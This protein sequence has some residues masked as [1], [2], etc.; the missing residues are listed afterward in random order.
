M[1]SSLSS[2]NWIELASESLA[3]LRERGGGT[4]RE[5]EGEREKM[6]GREGQ[7]ES[8]TC[9]CC[10]HYQVPFLFLVLLLPTLPCYIP[11]Q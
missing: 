10:T 2:S 5:R 1:R 6:V 8:S 3:P 7:R 11:R 4:E 9:T